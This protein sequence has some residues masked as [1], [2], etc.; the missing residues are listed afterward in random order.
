[1]TVPTLFLHGAADRILRP[2]FQ[3][4]YERYADEFHLELLDGVGHFICDAQPE[5]V[6]RRMIEFLQRD[7]GGAQIQD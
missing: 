3:R 2:D 4:G 7:T 5:R 1:L 6:A